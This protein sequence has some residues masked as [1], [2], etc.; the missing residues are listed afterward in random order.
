[1]FETSATA[2]CG[3]TGMMINKTKHR[4]KKWAGRSTFQSAQ[5]VMLLKDGFKLLRCLNPQQVLSKPRIVSRNSWKSWMNAASFTSKAF[6][7]SECCCINDLLW[8]L[9]FVVFFCTA[10]V[11]GFCWGPG[12]KNVVRNPSSGQKY[13]I[14]FAGDFPALFEADSRWYVWV[15]QRNLSTAWQSDQSGRD[16]LR[17][18]DHR[19]VARHHTTHLWYPLI[20]SFLGTD[21]ETVKAF[22][23]FG[24]EKSDRQ[25]PTTE[26]FRIL[27]APSSSALRHASQ[28]KLRSM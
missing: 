12:I 2:L 24:A 8:P 1:M 28:T 9:C 13:Q 20:S 16:P 7:R 10:S 27:H 4:S 18:A 15:P 25:P 17:S 19:I 3:T 14:I 26:P 11:S 21:I 22:G 6:T 23:A 5:L